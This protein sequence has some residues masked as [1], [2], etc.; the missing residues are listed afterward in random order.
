MVQEL[1]RISTFKTIQICLFCFDVLQ[2]LL[3][4]I[5]LNFCVEFACSPGVFWVSL[6]KERLTLSLCKERLCAHTLQSSHTN[7]TCLSSLFLQFPAP[8]YSPR[9]FPVADNKS[10]IS[11][12]HRK[13]LISGLKNNVERL[14]VHDVTGFTDSLFSVTRRW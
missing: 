3:K 8:S 6:C 10:E 1:H 13:H 7:H 5:Y 11:N 9:Y 14:N 4:D 12:I 2:R